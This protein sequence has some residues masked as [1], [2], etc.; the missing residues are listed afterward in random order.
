MNEITPEMLI[1]KIVTEY[2]TLREKLLEL[3]MYCLGCPS[4]QMESL[5]DACVIHGLD[6]DTV[7]KTLNLHLNEKEQ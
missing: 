7:T 2:P 6:P 3:G 5:K 1:G 4:S